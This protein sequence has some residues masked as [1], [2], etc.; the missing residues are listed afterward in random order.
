M[1]LWYAA[2]RYCVPPLLDA[3]YEWLFGAW[4]WWTVL[5]SS[6][7]PRG[8]R[9]FVPSTRR[10]SLLCLAAGVCSVFAASAAHRGVR[11]VGWYP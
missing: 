10:L 2:G 3:P 11:C 7:A 6:L 4:F 1:P 9:L 8:A 5:T